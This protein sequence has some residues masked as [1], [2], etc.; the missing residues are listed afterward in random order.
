M[1]TN[2]LDWPLGLIFAVSLVALIGAALYGCYLGDRAA[3]S[4]SA[5]IGTLDA[6]ILGSWP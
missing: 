2:G 6:A 5:S 3:E 4:T 1:L